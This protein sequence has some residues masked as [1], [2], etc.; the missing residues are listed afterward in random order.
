M[1]EPEANFPA[2]KTAESVSPVKGIPEASV[3]IPTH[4]RCEMLRRV[5]Q[6][7]E[8]Q[9][10]DKQKFE[11][12]VVVDG[13]VDN[14]QEMLRDHVWP[15]RPHVICQEQQGVAA[16]RNRGALSATASVLIFLDDDVAP[17][18]ELV[19]R[20]LES[21]RGQGRL[22]RRRATRIRPESKPPGWSRWL[23]WEIG[24][25]YG[26]MLDGRRS[27]DG[28]CLFSGNFSIDRSQFLAVGGFDKNMPNCEDTDLGLRLQHTGVGFSLNLEAIGHHCGYHDY[29]GWRRKAYR[30]GR[31]GGELAL[32]MKYEFVWGDLFVNFR[33]RHF[34]ARSAA[35]A[36]LDHKR[37]FATCTALMKWGASLAGLSRLRFLERWSYAGIY[38]LL[39][40]QGVCDELGN[41]RVF[42]RYLGDGTSRAGK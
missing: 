20:H 2:M 7:L 38:S 26:E 17:D 16:A 27:V 14:T 6:A 36:L 39:Y 22:R 21:H 25:Q 8:K 41:A 11:V 18:K 9:T 15:L 23:E 19:E 30:E 4:N 33:G 34:L 37:R 28:R 35:K 31:W 42:W 24:Q 5:I 13:S 3:I 12:I 32:N 40:W 1:T 10:Y 29:A